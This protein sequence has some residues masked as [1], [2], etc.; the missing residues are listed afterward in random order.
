MSEYKSVLN[1]EL[2]LGCAE[3]TGK[4]DEENSSGESHV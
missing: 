3:S 2:L 4:H 1:E